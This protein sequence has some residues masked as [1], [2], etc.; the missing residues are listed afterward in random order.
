MFAEHQPQLSRLGRSGPDGFAR[1]VTF[2]L[3]T[4]RQPL[5]IAA[6]DYLLVR[7]GDTSPL[8]GS[9]HAAIADLQ[10]RAA[11]LHGMC[12]MEY[13]R[14]TGRELENSLLLILTSIPG[15][16]PAKAG[17]VAQMIYGVSGCLDSHNLRRFSIPDGAYKLRKEG[18][19]IAQALLIDDYNRVISNLGGTEALWN[20]WCHFL[21]DR[22]PV[23]YPSA[24]RVSELHLVPLTA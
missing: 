13:A 17:F 22:D 16:G 1:I 7:R 6:A 8:F 11:D 18:P 20:S 4:I 14:C 19:L 24:E 21:S 9:K 5:R 2:A 15:I 12:E 10:E 3:L 23:N